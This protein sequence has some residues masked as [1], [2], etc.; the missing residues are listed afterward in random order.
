M[1]VAVQIVLDSPLALLVVLGVIALLARG[2]AISAWIRTR[3]F[4][5]GLLIW[6]AYLQRRHRCTVLVLNGTVERSI[7]FLLVDRICCAPIDRPLV[8]VIDTCG[9]E[10]DTGLQIMHALAAHEG[11]VHVRVPDEC[12]SAG[13]IIACGADT[14]YMLPHANLGHTDT[15]G[16]VDPSDLLAGPTLIAAASGQSIEVVRARHMLGYVSAAITKARMMRGA[17]AEDARA[18]AERLTMS[19]RDHREPLFPE[20]ARA[21]G[22][23]VVVDRDRAWRTLAW[24]A[25]W[26]R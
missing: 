8:L 3:W 22:L 10:V 15:I 21:I 25:G 5:A 24:L 2:P 18:L 7:G 6:R 26:A 16:H 12:W 17:T 9:G 20:D 23:P 1:G 4:R 13:T 11:P 19:D 14:I